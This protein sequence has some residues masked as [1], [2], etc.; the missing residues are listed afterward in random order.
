MQPVPVLEPSRRGSG[1]S[2]P[3]PALLTRTSTGRRARPRRSRR[4]SSTASATTRRSVRRT[5]RRSRRGTSPRSRRQCRRRCRRSHDLGALPR[6]AQR[7]RA[8]DAAAG[9]GHEHARVADLDALTPPV[10]QR[11]RAAGAARSSS[12]RSAGAASASPRA[13]PG[14]PGTRSKMNSLAHH[15]RDQ[16]RLHQ[17]E[18]R[19]DADPPPAAERQVGGAV[20]RACVLGHEALGVEALGVGPEA[21]VVVDRVDRDDHRRALRDPVAVDARRR[22]IATRGIAQAGG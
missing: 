16:R 22:A 11:S 5:R 10:R 4:A 8:A 18:A 9:P 6:A 13:R 7:G 1:P 21:R 2:R 15:R 19:A 20:V 14:G 17:R 12:P 3:T